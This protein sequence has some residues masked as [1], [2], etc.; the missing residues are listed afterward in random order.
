[1]ATGG[2]KTAYTYIGDFGQM[3]ESVRIEDL[4]QKINC[5]D[6]TL[7]ECYVDCCAS[8]PS[9]GVLSVEI[10]EGDTLI[11]FD[12]FLYCTDF[13]IEAAGF[14]LNKNTIDQ[15]V[16]RN[17]EL[18]ASYKEDD[19]IYRLYEP[20]AHSP[21]PLILFLHGGGECGTDNLLQLTGTL[22]AIKLAERFPDMFV[23]APQAPD[24]G[25]SMQE[26]FEKMLSHGDPYRVCIGADTDIGIGDRGWN[27]D[28]VGRVCDLIRKLIS[29]GKVD[30]ERVYAIGMSL[31]GAGVITAVSVA[32]DLFA[33]AVP[34]C[35]SMNADSYPLLANWPSIP[36]YIAS[37]YIDHQANR[38]AYI[39]RACSK[40]W[41]EGQRNVNFTLFTTEELEKYK[42]VAS[43]NLT[44]AQIRAANHKSW[45][46]VL[47]NEY[48]IL[49]WMISHRKNVERED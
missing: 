3:L 6:I 18:F 36:V 38:H 23:L 2:K 24:Y 42:I 48:G 40:L 8:I 26:M 41:A 31:G 27:R 15:V 35:P 4:T 45:I 1:M 12:P 44:E 30:A 7:N 47:H 13:S 14:T 39:L 17:E 19:V 28:Y 21:R 29:Q 5:E 32:P 11:T 25:I 34:I 22:G 43:P 46:L 16:I 20:K 10:S 9:K 49:D 37:A 33:A